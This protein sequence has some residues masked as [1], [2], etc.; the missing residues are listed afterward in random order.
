MTSNTG[1]DF[2]C[3]RP[4]HI[5]DLTQVGKH[6][7]KYE[8]DFF[9]AQEMLPHWTNLDEPKKITNPYRKRKYSIKK[10]PQLKPVVVSREKPLT[11]YELHKK[12]QEKQKMKE[13]KEGH[14]K[15][16]KW[17]KKGQQPDIRMMVGVYLK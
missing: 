11:K 16:L 8:E 6:S 14:Q 3:G 7:K 15:I 1:A 10:T 4:I 9:I 17:K 2:A 5:P 13:S 12:S